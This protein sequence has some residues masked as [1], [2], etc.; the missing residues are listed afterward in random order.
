[1]CVCVYVYVCV[2]ACVHVRDRETE[3]RSP[4]CEG[5]INKIYLPD[6]HSHNSH[7]ESFDHLAEANSELQ[8]AVI[9]LLSVRE[10]SFVDNTHATRYSTHSFTDMFTVGEAMSDKCV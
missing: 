10:K 9:K 1:M 4:N 8:F 2:Y 3:Q 5:E 6:L 7:F